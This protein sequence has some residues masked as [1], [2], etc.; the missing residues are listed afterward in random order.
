MFEFDNFQ[1]QYIFNWY[2]FKFVQFFVILE[3]CI[4]RK[5]EREK[6]NKYLIS[7]YFT[8]TK[9][10]IAYI[11]K[12][13]CVVKTREQCDFFILFFNVQKLLYFPHATVHFSLFHLCP[14]LHFWCAGYLW[15]GREIWRSRKGKEG[16]GG[17]LLFSHVITMI[18]VTRGVFSLKYVSY[19]D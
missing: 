4:K 10:I 3:S 8:L 6:R 1:F 5:R 9:V 2:I 16:E 19:R 18:K 11:L 15:D 13:N 12:K 17:P 7:L 14:L